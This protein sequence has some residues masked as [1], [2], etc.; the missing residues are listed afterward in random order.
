MLVWSLEEWLRL[1][2]NTVLGRFFSTTLLQKFKLLLNCSTS[3]RWQARTGRIDDCNMDSAWSNL[4]HQVHKLTRISS[5]SSSFSTICGQLTFVSADSNSTI[6]T[7]R[8]VGSNRRASLRI[9][10]FCVFSANFS[11]VLVAWYAALVANEFAFS[12]AEDGFHYCDALPYTPHVH[13]L[14]M[15]MMAESILQHLV[16]P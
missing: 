1:N 11:G 8:T 6:F 4:I 12:H 3:W 13:R 14:M 16:P 9:H 2:R 10:V 15:M 5:K 7:P